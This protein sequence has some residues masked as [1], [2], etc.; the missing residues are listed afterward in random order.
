MTLKAKIIGIVSI[1]MLLSIATIGTAIFKLWRLGPEL[2]SAASQVNT[3]SDSAIPLLITIKDIKADV[4]QVQG[5]L[6]DISATRGAPGFDDGFREAETYAK[7]FQ[8]H[9]NTAY[10]LADDLGLP[11]INAAIAGVETAFGPFYEA[12]K[13]MAQIYID[14]GPVAGNTQMNAF[15]ADAEAMA[16]AMESLISTVSDQAGTGLKSLY[17]QV[18][19]LKADNSRLI[20][21]LLGM[22]AVSMIILLASSAYLMRSVTRDFGALAKDV[23]RVMDSEDT[24]PL[25][26]DPERTDEFGP[27]AKALA[28]FRENLAHAKHKESELREAKMREMQAAREADQAKAMAEAEAMAQQGEAERQRLERELAAAQE[29][30]KVV[31]ACAVGDYSQRLDAKRFKGAFAD[32]AAGVN[33]ISDTTNKGLEDIKAALVE[34]SEGNLTYRM[35]GEDT[36]V[37]AE[38]Q[39]ALNATIESMASSIGQIEESSGLINESTTEVADAASALAQRTERTAATLEETAEAIQ[40]L[41]AHVSNSAEISA[42]A[43]KMA[44]EIQKQTVQGKEIVDATVTAIH[45]I[46][47]STAAISKTIT[48]IDDITFQ[49]NL[50]ALNAGV[51]AARAGEAGRGFAVVASEVRD[52]AARSSDAAQEISALIGASQEQVKKGVSMIDQTGSALNSIA[53][54]VS[55]IAVQIGEISSSTS[56][57]SN[58]ISEINLATKQL[59]QTTQENAAMFEETTA[60]SMSLKHEAKI[61]ARVVATFHTDE[62]RDRP[63]PVA[64][65]P[66]GHSA[67][68]PA[69]TPQQRSSSAL[70]VEAREEPDIDDSWDDF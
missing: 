46:H 9:V 57:Q 19:E 18:N 34:L 44:A 55:N 64:S 56:Q 22:V 17:L 31:A 12:G 10:V 1:I 62:D 14:D 30:S 41:S 27:I 3:V 35:T 49:T 47:T 43:N 32:I 58:S 60:T 67:A 51:E 21:L 25:T 52:L 54:G 29:I 23:E 42:N 28:A 6:T 66:E 20:A 45:E 11:E 36:G 16:T 38:I 48:L 33:T 8:R 68:S 39:G 13:G 53:D 40:A 61:L 59:D 15:D 37:F 26:L 7:A 4:I 70:A 2:V 24:E 69:P 65:K 63:A 5:W 50:L